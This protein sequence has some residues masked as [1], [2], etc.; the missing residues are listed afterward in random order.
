M[1]AARFF[2][3]AIGALAKERPVFGELSGRIVFVVQDT[4]AWTVRLG[5]L[6]QPVVAHAEPDADLVLSFGAETF[7]RFL[8]GTLNLTQ[9]LRDHEVA[10]DGNLD[11]LLSFSELLRAPG[12]T[13]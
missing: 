1:D 13:P 3:T 7:E 11:V 5:D 12:A 6:A 8:R 9:A 10:H 2:G 4:G